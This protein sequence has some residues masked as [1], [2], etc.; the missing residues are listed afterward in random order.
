MPSE[1]PFNPRS[2]R[3]FDVVGALLLLLIAM[4]GLLAI[5]IAIKITSPG[6]VFFRQWRYGLNNRKFRIYKFRTMRVSEGDESGV[7]QARP[8]DPRATAF[9]RFLR[10]SSLDELPQLLNV[11]TGEMSLVGPRPHVPG[12]KAGGM[13]YEELVPYYFERHRMRPGITGLAQAQGLRGSTEDPRRA[14]ARI[15]R[16]LDYIHNWRFG[17]DLRILVETLRIEFRAAGNGT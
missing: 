16:D 9:G 11:L 2:K 13:L 3:A 14:L 10:R 5:A 1:R 8:G 15:E 17:L 7:R 12:M 4:P 6:P